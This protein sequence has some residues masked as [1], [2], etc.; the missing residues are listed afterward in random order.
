MWQTHPRTGPVRPAG[1]IDIADAVR[2]TADTV[3]MRIR[4]SLHARFMIPR[5]HPG[6]T[7]TEQRCYN[8][9]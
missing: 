6:F 8:D 7:R 4:L 1:T 3:P 5:P 2:T 9:A